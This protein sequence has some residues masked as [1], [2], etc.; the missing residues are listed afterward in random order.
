M[1]NSHSPGASRV[2]RSTALSEQRTYNLKMNKSNTKLHGDKLQEADE[3]LVRGETSAGSMDGDGDQESQTPSAAVDE[4]AELKARVDSL[5]DSLLRAKA[6]FQNL[7]RRSAAERS[8][9]IRYANADLL[10]SLLN[11]LDDFD[12]SLEA[13]EVSDNKDAVVEGIR[14]VHTNLM[15]ALK[16]AGLEQVDALGQPFDPTIHEALLQQ[17]TDDFP[18]GTVVD[19]VARGYRLRD[20]VLRPARVIVS[21]SREQSP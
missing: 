9:A 5:E 6:D 8:D 10:K 17:P 12:R 1:K 2:W 7:Q 11:V 19:Q 15:K 21:K 3:A 18:P 16:E 13:A 4:A 14:L 20:R